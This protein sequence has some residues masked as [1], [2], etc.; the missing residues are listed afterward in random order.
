VATTTADGSGNWSLSLPASFGSTTITVTATLGDATGY[1]QEFVTDVALPGKTLLNATDLSGDD[2]GPGTY[3]YPTASDFSPGAFDLLGM[4]VSQTTTDVYIQVHIRN[5]ASTFG[6]DFGAQLLDVY[7]HN[8]AAT[9]TSTRPAYSLMNY[10]IAP[11]DAWD[12]RLEAQGFAPVA[13]DDPSGA[14][15]GSAQFIVDQPSGTATLEMPISE[16]GTVG[17]GWTFTVALTGQGAGN[18]PV[19]NFTQPAQQYSFGVCA[20]GDTSP[21]CS[22]N[23][24]NVAT[25]MD[26]IAPDGV[27]QASEWNLTTGAAVLQGVTVP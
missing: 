23:P 16:F 17:P 24:N 2:N 20:S 1:A 4:Q 8:P 15:L 11:A 19:R 3:Q 25:V 5:L 27:T 22:V 12:E 10:T 21:I 18:P 6:S 26:T 9:S 14:S 7:V 13:W